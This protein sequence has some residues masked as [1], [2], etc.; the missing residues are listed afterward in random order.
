M[1]SLLVLSR[2]TE[3]VA[4][5]DGVA[6]PLGFR[7]KHAPSV[8]IASEWLRTR[9]FDAAFF[10]GFISINDCK[11]L[12]ELL[13][14]LTPD[15]PVVIFDIEGKSTLETDEVRLIGADVVRGADTIEVL[16][17]ILTSVNDAKSAQSSPFEVLVVED[18][19]S[20]RDIICAYI[21]GLGVS[22]VT[23]VGSAKEALTLLEA[24]PARFSCIITDIRMPEITGKE[25]IEIIRKH[26]KLRHV[27]I[28]ALTAYGTADCLVDCLAV[29]ASGFLVKPPKKR[30]LI[31]EL[32]RAR[33]INANLHSPRLASVDEADRIRE[34]LSGRRS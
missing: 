34:I 15:A 14:Q 20:P 3:E 9:S 25:F 23:G 4:S 18:L 33:R 6:S 30:D 24:D 29:G 13:W 11:M 27:P 12:S 16:K 7:V 22:G 8:E 26:A 21:E 17:L 2:E 31:R 10:A 32:A 1:P 5:I 28:V 19:E